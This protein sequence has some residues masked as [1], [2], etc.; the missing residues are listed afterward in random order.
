[1]DWPRSQSKLFRAL[2]YCYPAEFRHEYGPE[3]EQL[4]A[5]R[6]QSEPRFR[7]WLETL[8]DLVC[9]AL[10]EHASVLRSD[11]RYG[12]RVLAAAPG[13]TTIALLVLALGIGAT[14]AV[15]S[16]V[17][18]VLLRSLPFGDPG[19]L[20]YLWS[21]NPKFR[22]APQELGP[23]VPDFYD[24]QRL[25]RSFS[26]MAMLSESKMSLVEGGIAHRVPVALVSGN[27]FRTLQA[28]PTFG[29]GIEMGD[30][31]PGHRRVAVISNGLWR[32]QFGSDPDI[33]GKQ[34]QLNRRR[35]IVIGVM[36][37]GFGYPLDGDIPYARSGFARTD[38]WLPL[39]YST[40]QKKNR[41][42]FPSADAAIGRLRDGVSAASAQEELKAIEL[43]LNELYPSI[44]QGFT[45]SVTPL[46]KTIIGPV[47]KMFWLLLGAALLVLLIA[48]GNVANLLLARA[49]ART[50]EMGIRA[51]LGAER[52]RIVR[53]LLTESLLLSCF[54]CALGI[55]FAYAAVHL[56]VRLNPGNIPRFDTASL[57]G[58]ALTVAV[59]LACITGV[60]CGLAPAVSASR[61]NLNQ[62]L[63]QGARNVAGGSKRGRFGLI[64]AEVALSVILLSAA[65]LL[66]RSYLNVMAV[67]PGFSRAALTFQLNLNSSYNTQQRQHTFYREFLAKL[68]DLHGVRYAGSSNATPLSGHETVAF[69][70]VRGLGRSKEMVESRSVTPGYR[71][72]I[73]TALL[74]G[75]DFRRS[76][77]DGKTPVAMVNQ[78]FVKAYFHG[79][80]PLGQQVRIG[81]GNF[82]GNWYTV[83]GMVGNIHHD[84]LAK[85]AKPQIILPFGGGNYFAVG[86]SIPVQQAIREIR[87]ALRSLDPTLAPDNLHTMGDRIEQNNARRRFQTALLTG[88][89]ALAVFLALAGLYA[90][91][92]YSVKRRTAEIGIRM[93]LGSPRS[94]VLG[95][96]LSQGLRLTAL[97]LLIGLGG[98]FALTRLVSGWLF[99]VQPADPLTFALVPA[100]VLAVACLAC[101][102]PAWNATRIDPIRTLRQE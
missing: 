42:N 5:D 40:A 63:K 44:W 97:G 66:I 58:S 85:P 81:V 99:D 98:A 96:I 30:E 19:K 67:S 54:G 74:L 15:Y 86:Y 93:A 12:L 37:K 8:A 27:F 34:I 7:L 89:A 4:F 51:A 79:R 16:L 90:V 92:S 100:F 11:L 48:A 62:L 70:E 75:R 71:A 45:A 21:P 49:A 13:F 35:Y 50:H 3:M 26:S 102:V 31:R 59:A 33:V 55:A 22:G 32:S 46:V 64:V 38:I 65:G 78:A 41:K 72:A 2:L 9:S 28:F 23:N 1:M 57:D 39:T 68:Q 18:A 91:M 29:R 88:F 61:A 20:V 76:D 60:L 82:M 95:L 10:R 69:A 53:Q 56:L 52:G 47:R 17:D 73:G 25:S 87:T 36:P 101:L 83:V 24:W 14:T 84:G 94:R 6:L 80:S 43:R 77:M